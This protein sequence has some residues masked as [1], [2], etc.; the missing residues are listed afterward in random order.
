MPLNE[1]MSN[2]N[3]K[4]GLKPKDG[5]YELPYI[6][7]SPETMV[8]SFDQMPFTKHSK[9]NKQ[10]SID[11]PFLKGKTRYANVEEGLWVFY[12][13]IDYKENISFKTIEMKDLPSDYYILSL[14]SAGNTGNKKRSLVNGQSYYNQSWLLFKPKAHNINC[15]FKD[16]KET[17]FTIYF[18]EKWLK[19]VLYKNSSFLKSNLKDFFES[20]AQYLIWPDIEC[21][22]MDLIQRASLFFKSNSTWEDNFIKNLKTIVNETLNRF[23]EKYKLDNVTKKYYEIP[24]KDRKEILRCEKIL[25]ANLNTKFSG[26]EALAGKAGMSPTKFKRCFK[27]VYGLAPFQYYQSKQMILAKEMLAEKKYKIGDLAKLFQYENSGKFSSA[28]KKNFGY[29]PSGTEPL[30]V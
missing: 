16:S 25:C 2:E 4:F 9:K 6:A 28:F 8:H 20:K 7:N 5:F 27:L 17:S 1:P 22:S 18:N 29:L 14:Q 24:S 10:L 15:C 19:K 11:T 26:I 30:S 23:I 3:L 21:S 12:N 13:N